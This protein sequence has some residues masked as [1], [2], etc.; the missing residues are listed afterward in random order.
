M[1]CYRANSMVHVQNR[2][3]GLQEALGLLKQNPELVPAVRAFARLEALGIEPETASA[4]VS[5][6]TARHHLGS[7]RVVLAFLEDNQPTIRHTG[8]PWRNLARC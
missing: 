4:P 8:R 3:L 5:L 1:H 6:R 2:I 7:W